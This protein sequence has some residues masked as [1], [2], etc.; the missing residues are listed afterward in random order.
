MRALACPLWNMSNTP[1][2]YTLTGSAGVRRRE[3]G[4]EKVH[5]RRR[6]MTKG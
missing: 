4:R 2:A 3:K 1:S 6:N 5:K